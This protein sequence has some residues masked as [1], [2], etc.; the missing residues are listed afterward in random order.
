MDTR[1]EMRVYKSA[2]VQSIT[3][4][5]GKETTMLSPGRED[6]EYE[7]ESAC[8]ISPPQS[9]ITTLTP[10]RWSW[11]LML[12]SSRRDPC[13]LQRAGGSHILRPQSNEANGCLTVASSYGMPSICL[14]ESGVLIYRSTRI[15][16]RMT[17]TD[18]SASVA[19]G[20]QL[21]RLWLVTLSRFSCLSFG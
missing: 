6:I 5:Q 12:E 11:R 20:M 16:R 3:L 10:A 17:A 14:V 21:V 4:N 7:D 13:T 8:G 9:I 15:P 1:Q 18:S 19:Y 2:R